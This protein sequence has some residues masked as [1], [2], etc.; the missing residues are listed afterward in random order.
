[1]ENG[2]R[3]TSRRNG[4]CEQ[5]EL[6]SRT[7]KW[8]DLGGESPFPP[9][10]GACRCD[11]PKRGLSALPS[12]YNTEDFA[13][14]I[15]CTSP[16]HDMERLP[17]LI[18][19]S[20]S[21]NL[22]TPQSGRFRKIMLQLESASWKRESRHTSAGVEIAK[23]HHERWDGTGDSYDALR[24]RRSCKKACSLEEVV[25]IIAEGDGWTDTQH[26]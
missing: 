19:F 15:S 4:D 8:M 5:G 6:H 18:G 12:S 25:R 14:C 20:A 22:S 21:Q 26:F 23:S 13:G 9:T 1:M 17:S 16:M 3:G 24:D 2:T 7:F 10:G 11:N